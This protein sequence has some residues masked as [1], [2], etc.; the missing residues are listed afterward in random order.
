[1]A[2]STNEYEL[3][4]LPT[5][6]LILLAKIWKNMRVY[7]KIGKMAKCLENLIKWGKIEDMQ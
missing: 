1:M 7:A 3:G 5:F 4:V 6:V 2:M